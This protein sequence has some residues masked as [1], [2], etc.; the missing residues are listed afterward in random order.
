MT[1]NHS[2]MDVSSGIDHRASVA[3]IQS[4]FTRQGLTLTVRAVD[5]RF[6]ATVAYSLNPSSPSEPAVG[7][8]PGQA[9]HRAWTAH[10]RQNSGSG[11]S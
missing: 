4:A 5:G 7:A 8:S 9:A 11:Q 2:S 6:E 3:D 1:E 10:L